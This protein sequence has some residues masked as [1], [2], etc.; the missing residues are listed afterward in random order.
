MFWKLTEELFREGKLK[1]HP[2]RV[3]KDGLVGVFE[4]M[5]E[6]REGRV[7]GVKLVYRVGETPGV[8]Q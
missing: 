2:I 8:G 1:P 4:G 5:Q 7:S 6:M 3:G